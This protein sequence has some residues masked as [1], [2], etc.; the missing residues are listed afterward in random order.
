[1]NEHQRKLSKLKK[2]SWAELQKMQKNAPELQ[3]NEDF[4]AFFPT[5]VGYGGYFYCDFLEEFSCDKFGMFRS[6]DG[7]LEKSLEI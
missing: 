2:F 6:V 4:C 7:H 1:M 5:L 3:E